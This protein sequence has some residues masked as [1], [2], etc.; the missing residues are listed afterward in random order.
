MKNHSIITVLLVLLVAASTALAQGQSGSHVGASANS[1]AGASAAAQAHAESDFNN[2]SADARE[3]GLAHAEN[4]RLFAKW[5]WDNATSTATGRFAQLT[6]D[7]STG[8]LA[9]VTLTS[10]NT[11]T[12]LFASVTPTGL[13]VT[14]AARVTGSLL[15]FGG[16]NFSFSA[17]NNPVA[18]WTYRV[19][20]DTNFTI[21]AASGASL[22]NDT[23]RTFRVNVGTALHGHVI[24]GGNGSYALSGGSATIIVPANGSLTFLGHPSDLGG[25]AANAAALHQLKD[26]IASQRVGGIA[27]IVNENGSAVE[28]REF[29]GVEVH[30]K[31]VKNGSADI[32]LS[33][34]DPASKAVVLHLDNSI[35]NGTNL[36]VTLD[37][38]KVPSA[39]S[40][41][42]AL[43][44]AG[45]AASVFVNKTATGIEVIVNV[46]HFSDH[47]LT[48]ASADTSTTPTTTTDSTSGTT[49]ATTSPSTTSKP[50]PG[51]GLVLA[52]VG[53]AGVAMLLRRK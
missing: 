28:D 47:D 7:A 36:T 2:L 3:K 43:S 25:F 13:A 53:L 8:G 33:S 5:S 1:H 17:H 50:A 48:I 20:V 35:A 29:L 39:A 49:P 12:P 26:A 4:A 40:E 30:A 32:T 22:V 34:T 38:Q 44:G 23:N 31:S 27:S 19:D 15:R 37:G 46:P 42:D 16:A 9:N 41:S 21:T 24:I 45:G 6:V 14:D 18:M 51:F 11:T 52:V 10:N